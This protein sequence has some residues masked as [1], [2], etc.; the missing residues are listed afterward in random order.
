MNCCKLLVLFSGKSENC[1]NVISRSNIQ[2]SR[3]IFIEEEIG[4][5]LWKFLVE[6]EVRIEVTKINE[7][8]SFRKF[9]SVAVVVAVFKIN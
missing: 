9:V 6:K 3:P 8:P 2:F 7:V 5:E 4:V 1:I